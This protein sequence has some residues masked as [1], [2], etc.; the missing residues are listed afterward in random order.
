[1]SIISP[2]LEPWCT[3]VRQLRAGVRPPVAPSADVQ[4]TLT[5]QQAS[6]VALESCLWL[7]ADF[8]VIARCED[9][10]PDEMMKARLLADALLG[11]AH[12][13]A[14]QAGEC[15][16]E[17]GASSLA[18]P[19]AVPEIPRCP[20]ARAD[21][22]HGRWWWKRTLRGALQP[23]LLQWTALADSRGV[24]PA[25]MLYQGRAEAAAGDWL[26]VEDDGSWCGPVYPPE[27]P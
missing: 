27:A 9:V 25:A 22:Q 1:M 7:I 4:P 16:P 24:R 20:L 6:A 18:P 17:E 3:R 15:P 5:H 2:M 8:R 12:A 13:L 19:S 21:L 23:V 14:W 26:P 10:P 11:T